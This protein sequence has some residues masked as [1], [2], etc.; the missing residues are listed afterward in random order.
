MSDLNVFL[1]TSGEYS[2]YSVDSAWSSYELAQAYIDLQEK[3]NSRFFGVGCAQ[4]EVFTLNSQMPSLGFQA[5]CLMSDGRQIGEATECVLGFGDVSER[6]ET[7]RAKSSTAKE[8]GF[9]GDEEFVFG[10]GKTPES[11]LKSAQDYR[12]KVLAERN[13]LV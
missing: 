11:A 13:G 9:T 12:A 5:K 6:V 7:V 3:H 8:Y 10:Q 2:D 1:V 4:I